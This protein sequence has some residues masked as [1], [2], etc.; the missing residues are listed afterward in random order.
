M[1]WDIYLRSVL[2]L[3][4]VLALIVGAAWMARRFGLGGVRLAGRQ[5]HL[6]VAEVLPLDNRRRL[7]LVRRDDVQHLLLIGG[8]ADIV[9]ETG[10]GSKGAEE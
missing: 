7:V 4:A 6:S 1:D 8:G 3:V 10:I 2:A 5:R 9:V